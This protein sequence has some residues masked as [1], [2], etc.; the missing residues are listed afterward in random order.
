M[1]GT[2][3]INEDSSEKNENKLADLI[4][5]RESVKITPSPLETKDQTNENVYKND[6]IM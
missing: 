3:K 4:K 5:E 1:K 2:R 6:E